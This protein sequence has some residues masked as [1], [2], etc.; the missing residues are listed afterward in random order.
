MNRKLKGYHVTLG[1]A[2]LQLIRLRL[3]LRGLVVV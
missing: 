3:T 1:H 2:H